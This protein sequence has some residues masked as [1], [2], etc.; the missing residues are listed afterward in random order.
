MF[1]VNSTAAH[2]GYDMSC[3]LSGNL[4]FFIPVVL[5]G[6]IIG[7][8]NGAGGNTKH[9]DQSAGLHWWFISLTSRFFLGCSR[10]KLKE[11]YFVQ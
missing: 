8:E 11:R 6:E 2:F 5:S 7:S 3:L 9:D 4:I 10:K 1:P